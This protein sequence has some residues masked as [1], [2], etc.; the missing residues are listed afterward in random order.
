MWKISR[1]PKSK[2]F[3]WWSR[4][5]CFLYFYHKFAVFY[6]DTISIKKRPRYST[7]LCLPPSYYNR[8]Q[9]QWDT[10][11]KGPRRRMFHRSCVLSLKHEMDGN[12]ELLNWFHYEYPT[13]L[14]NTIQQCMKI[15]VRKNVVLIKISQITKVMWIS[16]AYS[17]LS[18]HIFSSYQE[19]SWELTSTR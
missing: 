9:P 12:S 17:T 3:H 6:Q 2:D 15:C 11:I 13:T 8:V 14:Q 10:S 18:V 1:K 4:N 19:I 5:W 7:I 16:R